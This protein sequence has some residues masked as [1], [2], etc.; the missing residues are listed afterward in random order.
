MDH[1]VYYYDNVSPHN[2]YLVSKTSSKITFV[3]VTSISYINNM[4]IF[5]TQ[6]QISIMTF[7]AYIFLFIPILHQAQLSWNTIIHIYTHP[8]TLYM[9]LATIV[10]NKYHKIWFT[11]PETHSHTSTTL[12]TQRIMSTPTP[13]AHLDQVGFIQQHDSS[14]PHP[15]TTKI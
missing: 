13:T 10:F 4:Y 8:H 9:I 6:D 7:A 14:H 11:A 2:S 15:R 3:L 5:S 1:R 12:P